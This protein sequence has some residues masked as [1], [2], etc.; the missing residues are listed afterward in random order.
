MYGLLDQ[1]A[2]LQWVKNNIAAFGG[3]PANVTVFGESAGA[4]A[5]GMLLSSPLAKGLFQ[6]AIAESGAFWE[7]P[8][9]V[10]AS[11]ATAT[12]LGSHLGAALNASTPGTLRTLSATQVMSDPTEPAYNPTVDGYVL[13]TDPYQR[14]AAGLQNDVP[15]LEGQNANEGTIFAATA[16]IPSDTKEHFIAAATSAFGPTNV[17]TFLQFYPATTDAQ[18]QQSEVMLAG[19]LIIASQTWEM[20]NLQK[21]TGKS[22]VYSY[23]FSQ[24]S[25]YNPLPIHVSEVP[26]VF[27][28]L[29]ANGHAAPNASDV[30]V[31]DAMSSYWTNFAKTGNPNGTGLPNW[32]LYTGAGGQVIGLAT[33]LQ[34]RTEPFTAQF[35]F[36]NSFRSPGS[37]GFS[38]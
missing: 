2:A 25:P 24:T 27:Q 18:A 21:K 17:N 31:A 33:P 28:N 3:D 20:A 19:D 35:Q 38:F 22:P 30:A 23:F 26:Y 32:P 10:M 37:L 15:L 4:H 29:V 6:K 7:T 8:K 12:Q 1:L 9:G 5:V 36:L 14:F 11:H 34:A 16:G 13:P